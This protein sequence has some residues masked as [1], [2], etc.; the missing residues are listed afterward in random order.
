M[1]HTILKYIPDVLV[2]ICLVFGVLLI[3]KWRKQYKAA[4]AF[5]ASL[6]ASNTALS[7]ANAELKTQISVQASGNV[8]NVHTSDSELLAELRDQR[9]SGGYS[10]DD[11]LLSGVRPGLGGRGDDGKALSG[12]SRPLLDFDLAELCSPRLVGPSSPYVRDDA[13]NSD[14]H[15]VLDCDDSEDVN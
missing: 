6:V 8:V 9:R 2:V 3:L 12:Q 5:R 10:D 7:A 4:V 11:W 14:S 1:L 13:G 15:T